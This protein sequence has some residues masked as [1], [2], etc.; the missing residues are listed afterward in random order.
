[1]FVVLR[2][3]GKVIFDELK[4]LLVCKLQN[5]VQSFEVCLKIFEALCDILMTANW[6]DFIFGGKIAYFDCYS[7]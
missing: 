3:I 1:L 6:I 7:A 4:D 2:F 5:V